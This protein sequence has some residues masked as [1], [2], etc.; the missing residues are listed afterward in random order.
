MKI[1]DLDYAQ[2]KSIVSSKVLLGQYKELDDK[3]ELFAVEANVSWETCILKNSSE[4]TDFEANLKATCNMPLEYRS[5]D[6]L[7]K[8]AS[9]KFVEALNLYVDGENGSVSIGDGSTVYARTHYSV[10]FT[11]A[12][13]D[14]QWTNANPGDYVDFEVGFYSDVNNEAT[15]TS[16]NKFGNKYKILGSGN[17]LF[18]VP[19]VKVIPSSITIAPGVIVDIYIRAKFVN[20]GSQD[21]QV[22]LNIVGWK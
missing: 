15:F 12:G 19:T 3:Y 17:R 11:L 8:V 18:D 9:A 14:L 1:V 21:S 13:V 10:P 16:L 5:S 7:P 4:G 6:G 2:F 20:V 22:A